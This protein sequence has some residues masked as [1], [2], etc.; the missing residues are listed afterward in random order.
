MNDARTDRAPKRR[1]QTRAETPFRWT[2]SCGMSLYARLAG[3]R[4]DRIFRE[5]DA[6]VQAYTEGLPCAR[7]LYGP[8]VN[9]GGPGWAGISYGHVNCL[10]SELVFP[11]GYEVAHT[12]IYGSLQEGI[13]AL[14]KRADWGPSEW[15]SAGLMPFYLDLWEQLKEAFPGQRIA[16]GGFGAEG[17]ITT[18]WEL[19]GHGFFVDVYDDPALYREFLRLVTDSVVSY[20][21]FLRAVNG[22]PAFTDQ[23]IGLYDDVASMIHPDLWPEMVCPFHERF[24]ARQTSGKR[25][26]HIENLVPDHLPF[27]DQL[28]LDSFDP[29]VSAKLTPKDLNDRCSVPFEWRLNSMQVRDFSHEE[30]RRFVFDAVA[31]GASGVFCVIAAIM[32]DAESAAKVQTFMNAAKQVEMLLAEECPRQRL[33]EHL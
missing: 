33:G 11:T 17:P 24:F 5:R 12:P 27:L 4:F 6:I 28:A 31:D 7:E 16:F 14:A 2:V 1:S 22:Q 9:Y 19:R 29:S 21:G 10:G 13:D 25:H 20:F 18:A 30:I 3:V 26:A 23:R 32:A 15:A 8:E